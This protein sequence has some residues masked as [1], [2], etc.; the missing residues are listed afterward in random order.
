MRARPRAQ[1]EWPEGRP[2]PALPAP[3]PWDPLAPPPG[4]PR[5]GRVGPDGGRQSVQAALAC[6]WAAAAGVALAALAAAAAGYRTL[7]G[8]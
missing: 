2:G 8:A 3:A 5:K 6:W 7:G 1:L 4:A